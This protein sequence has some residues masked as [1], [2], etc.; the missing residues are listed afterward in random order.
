MSIH[1]DFSEQVHLKGEENNSFRPDMII[2]LPGKKQIIIDA[3]VPLTA[4]L[5]AV[6]AP[7]ESTREKKLR[8]HARQVKVH[9]NSLSNKSYWSHLKLNSTPEFVIL[10]LPG[11]AFFSS[12]LE[13]DPSLIE[14]GAQKHVIIA[15]PSTLIALLHT[16]AYGW[17]QDALTENAKEISSI[18]NELYK[19]IS[20]ITTHLNKLGN[21]LNSSVSSYNKT[22]GT[23]ERRIL[24]SARKFKELKSTSDNI[25]IKPLNLIN[26]ISR[27]IQ[28][29]EL[30]TNKNI[31]L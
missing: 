24:P 22:I 4:Y 12:A 23:L 3:K 20:D 7:D 18:G 21:D 2:N 15:T 16:I 10:F 27:N 26:Q 30:L 14:E 25:K 19:R 5:D 17:K 13:K 6:E 8:D 11:E 1:C 28:S 9:I 31:K 29:P